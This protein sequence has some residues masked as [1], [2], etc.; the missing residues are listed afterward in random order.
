MKG[1]VLSHDESSVHSQSYLLSPDWERSIEQWQRWLQLSGIA[2][3]SMKLR[4]GHVRAI[5]RRSGTVHPG[6]IDLNILVDLCGEPGWSNDHRKGVRTSLVSFFEWCMG[7]GLIDHN[8][9]EALPRVKESKPNPKPAPDN[10]WFDLLE[11]GNPRERLMARLAGEAGMRRAE[12][13]VTHLDDLLHD[14]SGYSLIVHG[15]GGKQRVVPITEHLAQEILEHSDGRGGF[16]FPGVDRW[17]NVVR[18]HVTPQHVGK[19]IG[20]LMPKG[21]SIHKL[22]HRYA[23]RGYAGTGNLRAVQEALGHVSVAT[24]Q[25]YVAVSQSEVRGVSEAAYAGQKPAPLR[26]S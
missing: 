17:G 2:K 21:W 26:V 12:V 6:Q 7:R 9:A 25:R 5:A 24:T 16:L 19:L 13:A 4:R 8:P 15:K 3:A 10:I 11:A 22:R 18:D 1:L 20:R 23:T 14:V